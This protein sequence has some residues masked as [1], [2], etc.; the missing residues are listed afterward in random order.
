MGLINASTFWNVEPVN[1]QVLLSVLFQVVLFLSLG[2]ASQIPTYTAARNICYKQ[3][4][5]NFYRTASPSCSD[6]WSTGCAA[7]CFGETGNQYRSS[8]F[9]VCVYEGVDY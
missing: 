8:V 5:A 3:R 1:V 6:H 7:L 9:E 2:Q 4:G